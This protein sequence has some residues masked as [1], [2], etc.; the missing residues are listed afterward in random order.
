M[1][2]SRS[3]AC[4]TTAAAWRARTP[5]WRWNGT[6]PRSSESS[7]DLQSIATHGFRG[8]ALPSI[9]AVSELLLRTR[10]E[11]DSAGT[12]VAVEHGRPRHVRDAGHPRGTTV[13]VRDLFG[14]VPAR[15]KFLRSAPTEAS[16]VAEA[17]TQLAL[18]RPGTGFSLRSAGRL[19]LDAPPA[20]GLLARIYQLFGAKLRG[21][22][23]A[24]RGW[25]RLGR[26][27]RLRLPAR[28]PAAGAA[29]RCGCS[30]TGAPCA[31]APSR[32][33]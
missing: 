14:A 12:E 18:A 2:G 15:R 5:R 32:G 27:P 9:A 6:R 30:S 3:S 20:E 25:R 23:G 26:R 31:T 1:A 8:E 10:T 28:P 17:L 7:S 29:R 13:E 22:P 24:G 21:G 19:L 4:A 11:A 33:P 16:H